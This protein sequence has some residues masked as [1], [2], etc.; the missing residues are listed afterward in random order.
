MSYKFSKRDNSYK[1]KKKMCSVF[2]LKFMFEI[3]IKKVFKSE[4]FAQ[5]NQ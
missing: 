2:Y 3:V 1:M 4:G 5:N